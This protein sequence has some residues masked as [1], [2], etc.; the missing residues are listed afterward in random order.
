MIEKTILD[1]LGSKLTAACY[2][3]TPEQTPETYVLIDKTGESMEDH[4]WSATVA[5]QCIAPTLYGAAALCESVIGFMLALPAERDVSFCG[6]NSSY[7][8]TNPE[9]K[10]YR[11]QAVFNIFF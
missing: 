4:V 5:V 3:E 10:E 6:L 1:Y 9:T 11:Y 8:F 7:N 2:M